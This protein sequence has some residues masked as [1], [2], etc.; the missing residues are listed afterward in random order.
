M[1]LITFLQR[2]LCQFAIVRRSHMCKY[3]KCQ[4]ISTRCVRYIAV[5][6]SMNVWLTFCE[7]NSNIIKVD[8][9]CNLRV[10]HLQNGLKSRITINLS[11]SIQFAMVNRKNAFARCQKYSQQI[12]CPSLLHVQLNR[13]SEPK[14][15]GFSWNRK[16]QFPLET[17]SI[18][19]RYVIPNS[20]PMPMQQNRTDSQMLLKTTINLIQRVARQKVANAIT[21]LILIG[22]RKRKRT[23]VT[24]MVWV[25][26]RIKYDLWAVVKPLTN[27]ADDVVRVAAASVWYMNMNTPAIPVFVCINYTVFFYNGW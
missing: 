10:A 11:K 6:F 16:S 18:V 27:P 22:F 3:I 2:V 9:E 17:L 8:F 13:G 12:K 1:H 19:L 5:P 26:N 7:M 20:M 4:F 14:M 25:A 21:K 23:S 15:C 24:F